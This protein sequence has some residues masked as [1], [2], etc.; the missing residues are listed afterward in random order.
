LHVTLCNAIS[1]T[2]HH[3]IL[4]SAAASPAAGNDI[5]FGRSS[6]S[7]GQADVVLWAE[8]VSQSEPLIDSLML[9]QRNLRSGGR[10]VA[11]ATADRSDNISMISRRLR[12]LIHAGSFT[13]II[14]GRLI[15]E[16][17]DNILGTAI[18]NNSASWKQRCT[19][20]IEE[21]WRRQEKIKWTR[22]QL[23]SKRFAARLPMKSIHSRVTYSLEASPPFDVAIISMEWR[24]RSTQL[25]FLRC[26]NG[27]IQDSPSIVACYFLSL[28]QP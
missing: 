3:I 18:F 24:L 1:Q 13:C 15:T 27:S 17:E 20:A 28:S 25:I 6:P 10:L 16:L 8:I 19:I 4:L 21:R 14:V 23:I 12:R 9:L 7:H 22:K 2:P 26:R 11:W 5:R